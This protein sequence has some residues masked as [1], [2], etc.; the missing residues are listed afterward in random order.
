MKLY[1]IRLGENWDCDYVVV[2]AT[3]KDVAETICEYAREECYY[4]FE[5]KELIAHMKEREKSHFI[6]L[7]DYDEIPEHWGMS[8][9]ITYLKGK[10][11]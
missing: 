1:V 9:Q 5:E 11:S 6:D 10:K 7:L 3:L 2:C 8:V 4:C